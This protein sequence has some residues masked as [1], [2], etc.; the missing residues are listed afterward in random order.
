MCDLETSATKRPG[1]Y[2]GCCVTQIKSPQIEDRASFY[3]SQPQVQI[4]VVVYID[5]AV[6]SFLTPCSQ[7]PLSASNYITTSS[8]TPPSIRYSII[9]SFSVSNV[10]Y[11]QHLEINDK[12][13]FIENIPLCLVNN[14]MYTQRRLTQLYIYLCFGNRFRS[15]RPSSGLGFYTKSI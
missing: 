6:Y 13:I 2:L 3:F 4:S 9:L 14:K 5:K 12:Q 7:V 8:F 10:E 11:C 15:N 1:H